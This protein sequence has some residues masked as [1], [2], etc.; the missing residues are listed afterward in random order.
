MHYSNVQIVDPVTGKAVRIGHK[1][2]E[3]GTK[4]RRS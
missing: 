1:F 2:L 4:A 3:D